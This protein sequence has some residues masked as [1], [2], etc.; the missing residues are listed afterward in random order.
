MFGRGGVS[1]DEQVRYLEGE[2]G[3]INIEL[4]SIRHQREDAIAAEIRALGLLDA[5]HSIQARC[6]TQIDERL[7]A[8]S[9]LRTEIHDLLPQ[10][11][12]AT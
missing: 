7:E 1:V 10:Q 11:R 2:I 3:K 9:S 8:I 5:A 12:K 4:I 6:L